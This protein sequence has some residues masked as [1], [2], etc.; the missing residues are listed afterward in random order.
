MTPDEHDALM[1]L[2]GLVMWALDPTMGKGPAFS[3]SGQITNDVG[4]IRGAVSA[5]LARDPKVDI[6]AADIAAAIPADLARQVADELG[7]R[8]NS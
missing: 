7:K 2:K 5:L 4:A 8:L 6:N 3:T 1:Y